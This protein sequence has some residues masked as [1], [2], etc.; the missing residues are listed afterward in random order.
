MKQIVISGLY[1]LALFS[2]SQFI[3]D[4]MYLYYEL[5]WLDIPMHIL[6]GFG[7]A[8][9]ASAVYTYFGKP[10]SFWNLFI[11]FTIVAIVWELYEYIHDIIVGRL[12]TGW[13]DATKDYVDGTIGTVAAYYLMKK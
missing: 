2:V 3:F 1:L 11:A 13:L 12:W 8:S 10:V 4:P 5:R 9:L 7:V 6:G